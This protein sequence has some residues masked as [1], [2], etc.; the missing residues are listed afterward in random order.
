MKNAPGQGL[1]D[2]PDTARDAILALHRRCAAG[3]LLL[4]L[5]CC[6][7]CAGVA[8][9][10]LKAAAAAAGTHPTPIP[11]ILPAHLPA[12]AGWRRRAGG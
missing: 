6:W 1:P 8:W 5:G 10:A 7:A 3:L 2:S 4:L 12:A 9:T 11:A